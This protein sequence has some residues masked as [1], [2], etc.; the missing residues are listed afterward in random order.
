MLLCYNKMLQVDGEA[1]VPKITLVISENV[2]IESSDSPCLDDCDIT[3]GRQI[4]HP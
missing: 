3:T 1:L 4:T 2:A